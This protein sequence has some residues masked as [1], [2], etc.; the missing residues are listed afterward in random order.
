MKFLGFGDM[1]ERPDVPLNRKDKEEFENNI[2]L[3]K[4]EIREIG[5]REGVSAYLEAGDFLDSAKYDYEFLSKIMSEWTPFS[6]NKIMYMLNSGKFTP[7]EISKEMGNVIPMIGI[8]GNHELFGNSINTLPKTS[9]NF[10]SEIG[11]LQF[12]TKDN[13]VYFTTDDGL[14]IAITG[15]HYHIGMDKEEFIDDYIVNEKLG[16]Y[17]IHIVHGYLTNKDFGDLFRH[18]TVDAIAHR[19]KADLTFAGHDHIGF[20]LVEVDGKY[21]INPGSPVRSKCDIKEIKRRPKVFIVDITK[22]NGL[23]IKTVYLKS[24]KQ[25]EDVLD[26]TTIE[27]EQEKQAKIQEIKSTV[28][29]AQIKKGIDITEIIEAISDN[30]QIN[31]EWKKDIINAVTQNIQKMKPITYNFK[32]YWITDIILENF[33]SHKDTHIKCSKKLNMF[34]G[35]SRQGKTSIIRALSWIYEDKFKD[36]RR[37]IHKEEDYARAT[38]KLSNGYSISRIVERK[39]TGKNGY[40]IYDP[41]LNTTEYKNTKAIAEV[42]EI[43]GFTSLDI[44]TSK[45]I[46]LNFLKQGKSWFFI[47]DSVS[48][49]ER[50]KIIGGIYGTHYVD[51]VLKEYELKKRRSSRE[52][53][54]KVKDLNSVDIKI[55]E[56]DHLE[57]DKKDIDR[58]EMIYSKVE[59]LIEKRKNIENIINTK[60]NILN[61][62]KKMEHIINELICLPKVK[63]KM[64]N[65]KSIYE[66]QVK[67][68]S[69][70]QKRNEILKK[71]LY[72]KKVKENTQNILEVREKIDKLKEYNQLKITKSEALEKYNNISKRVAIL[73]KKIAF[74]NNYINSTK[75]LEAISFKITRLKELNNQKECI[76]IKLEEYNK[77]NKSC[78]NLSNKIEEIKLIINRTKDIKKNKEKISQLYELMKKKECIKQIKDNKLQICAKASIVNKEK[79]NAKI[80]SEKLI[81]EYKQL[82]ANAGKCPVCHGT[83]DN[84][85]INRIVDKYTITN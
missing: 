60:K 85:V 61:K 40:E 21:F 31:E 67:I 77:L 13:P 81:V 39:K 10:L 9:I 59:V 35:E 19:T 83:I 80:K 52:I 15:T 70:I 11:L 84:A 25:G 71:G 3:K 68:Q 5:K 57:G 73:N 32:D 65:L 51:A 69:V 76:V 78:K 53:E 22:E 27:K 75:N 37:L 72:F 20:G 46:P 17:H 30:R 47:G 34:I 49:T 23:K 54:T 42:Q 6:I 29:K 82:L 1:H 41:N 79:T 48:S 64:N 14:K 18:T 38:I 8:A 28:Q 36:S 58:L 4:N 33:Q 43:L 63:E 44:G 62:I 66:K 45:S 74:Y 2:K 56:F 7:D 24:A 16:D 50:A 12:A 26:R 55:K